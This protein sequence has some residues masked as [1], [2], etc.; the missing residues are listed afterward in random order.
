MKPAQTLT[1]SLGPLAA[2]TTTGD[3]R[4]IVSNAM[5]ALARKEIS[6]TDF[7]A[8]A[9]GLDA[10]SGS[11]QTEVNIAKA[12]ME[13]LKNGGKLGGKGGGGDGPEGLGSL[14]IGMG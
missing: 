5:L 3:L 1:E 6:A 10:V 13:M 9:K 14:P 7:V 11:L 12:R 8:L 4:R 2:V